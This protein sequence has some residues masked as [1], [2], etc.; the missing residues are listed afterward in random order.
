MMVVRWIGIIIFT[1][2]TIASIIWIVRGDKGMTEWSI[3]TKI[4]CLV[5]SAVIAG[6]IFWSTYFTEGG[7][8]DMRDFKSETKGGYVERT[9][10]VYDAL[11][12]K[13]AHYEGKFDTEENQDEGT[14]KVKFDN[15]GKRTIIYTM[16]GTVII[17]DK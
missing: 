17:N 6:L 11:G 8:R 14:L 3:G 4:L 5:V 15:D 2:C 12:Q 13:I 9:L 7:K 1:C 16:S 10:D